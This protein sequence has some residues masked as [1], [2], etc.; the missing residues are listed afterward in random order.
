MEY[1][2]PQFY[3]VMAAARS[4][5]RDVV[6]CAR[7]S[8]DWGPPEGVRDGL[9][10]MAAADPNA[11]EY[12]PAAGLDRLRR[13]I[14]DRRG[15]DPERV[16]VTN[17]AGAANHV[18]MA[19]ALAE[20]GSEIVAADPVYPYYAGRASLLG[21]RARLV[22][23][24]DEGRLDPDA[25]RAA[26]STDTAAVVI[27]TPNNPTGQTLSADAI[28]ELAAIAAHFDAILISDEVYDHFVFAGRHQSAL[29]ADAPAVVTN[30]F[31][32]TLAVP[33]LRVGYLVAPADLI[34]DIES[35]HLLTN[36]ATT[37]PGQRAV[38]RALETTRPDWY[39]T[40]RRRV[41][42]RIATF[43]AGLDAIGAEYYQPDGGFYVFARLPGVGGSFDAVFEMIESGGVAAMPGAAF[44][45][46]RSEWLRFSM[47]TPRIETAVDRLTEYVATVEN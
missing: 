9:R 27:T 4:A 13:A 32:K 35:R 18:A 22:P 11:Y 43:T 15:V 36:V 5:D 6:D 3:R 34:D 14:A 45:D 8:P 30:S 40:N 21:N 1:R 44:G 42:D 25:V 17:G 46:A 29:D 23:V 37:R 38:A 28:D 20:R 7:G 24:D 33:G 16:L 47:L 39:A 2:R 41:Q 19:T 12:P 26:A 31:S 10:S